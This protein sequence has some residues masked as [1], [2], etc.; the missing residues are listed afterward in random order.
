M[1]SEKSN[2]LESSLGFMRTILIPTS[3]PVPARA[4]AQ[5]IMKLAKRFSARIVI[6]H[7][8]DQGE[9][10]DGDAALDIFDKVAREHGI[11]HVLVPAI[12]EISS[13]IIGQAK[14]H[15]ADLIVMGATE[16]RGV[17]GWIVDRILTN[18]EIPVLILPWIKSEE[19]S[20]ASDCR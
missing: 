7:I 5:A 16:G 6:V 17:A 11:E 13:T 18:T 1:Y 14:Y 4:N 3:G 2:T 15:D 19:R 20:N 12:G 9:S 10:R 8:R